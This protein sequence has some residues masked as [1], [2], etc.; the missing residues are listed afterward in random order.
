VLVVVVAAA[1]LHLGWVRQ[2]EQVLVSVQAL[3]RVGE[4]RSPVLVLVPVLVGASTQE[5]PSPKG[6]SDA[7]ES[8]SICCNVAI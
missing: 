1:A 2:Q 7:P 4:Q 8:R 6:K 3:P 5:S